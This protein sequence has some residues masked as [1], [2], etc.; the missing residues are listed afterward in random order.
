MSENEFPHL[1]EH[2][3]SL[4]ETAQYFDELAAKNPEHPQIRFLRALAMN[5]KA[6]ATC[7]RVL[8]ER[9]AATRERVDDRSFSGTGEKRRT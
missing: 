3:D 5:V 9:A 4:R 7:T 6:A 1:A 8:S 2:A